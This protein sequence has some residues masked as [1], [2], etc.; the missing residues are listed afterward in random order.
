MTLMIFVVILIAIGAVGTVLAC[1]SISSGFDAKNESINDMERRLLEEQDELRM[2]RR[3]LRRELDDLKK[4]LKDSSKK[5]SVAP[6]GP[7][8]LKDWLIETDMVDPAQFSRAEKYAAEKNLDLISALLTLNMI[9]ID[10]YEK[11][12]K[13]KLR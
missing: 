2:R 5:K 7:S 13:M 11:A 10:T 6:Q 8:S 1:K 9:T 3:D 4:D 12:K